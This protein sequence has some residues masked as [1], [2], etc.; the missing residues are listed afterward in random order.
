MDYEELKSSACVYFL[1]G[2]SED[3]GLSNVYVGET[4]VFGSRVNDHDYKKDWW[5]EIKSGEY[6]QYYKSMY[7][8]K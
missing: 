2:Q 7:G 1:V 5:Q 6:A 3:G 8:K 4:D